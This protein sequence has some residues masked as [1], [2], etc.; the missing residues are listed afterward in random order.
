MAASAEAI[1]E[2]YRGRYASFRRAMAAVLRSQ[3]LAHDVVQEA[4]AQALHDREQYRGEGSLAA[5]IWR[6]AFRIAVRSRRAGGREVTIEALIDDA[7]S[8]SPERDP[9]LAAA[10]RRL[11]PKRRLIVFLR[12]FADLSYS[13][14]ASV[15]EISEGTVAAAIAQAR[16]DLHRQ[17][18]PEE[19]RR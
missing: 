2:L 6:I 16:A 13:E 14:I 4:F 9:E 19:A 17:L 5:W 8:P 1:E 10:L 18:E 7:A 11:P 12:Y 15:C 3:D